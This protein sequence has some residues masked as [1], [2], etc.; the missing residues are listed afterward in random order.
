MQTC[1]HCEK[2]KQDKDFNFIKRINKYSNVC[3][4]CKKQID[5]NRFRKK[6]EWAVNFK[7]GCCAFCGYDECLS[8]LEFHH[9]TASSKD[10]NPATIISSQKKGAE[11][12]VQELDKC[13]LLCANCHAEFHYE[14]DMTKIFVENY[15][16]IYKPT[17]FSYF[18]TRE[19]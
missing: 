18:K 12:L 15:P 8:A 16:D 11:K 10:D 3:K 6:K 9:R 7:G 4:D 14:L 19:A 17:R 2:Q 13:I 5:R 1:T